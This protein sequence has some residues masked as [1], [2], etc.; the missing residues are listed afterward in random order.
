[1]P[2]PKSTRF[3]GTVLDYTSKNYSVENHFEHLIARHKELGPIFKEQVIKGNP[4][5]LRHMS[6]NALLNSS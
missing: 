1:M 6:N 5:N 4:T 3:F 2:K